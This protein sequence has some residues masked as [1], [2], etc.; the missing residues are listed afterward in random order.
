MEKNIPKME[1]DE[2]TKLEEDLSIINTFRYEVDEVKLDLGKTLEKNLVA[3]PVP[4]RISE[5]TYRISCLRGG[6]RSKQ[7]VA[8][9]ILSEEDSD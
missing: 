4:G 7:T 5:S 3:L 6:A 9:T 1:A 2:R 8:G